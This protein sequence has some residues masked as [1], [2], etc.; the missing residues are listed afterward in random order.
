[1]GQSLK[2]ELEAAYAKCRGADFVRRQQGGAVR[3]NVKQAH[4]RGRFRN[5]GYFA[6]GSGNL[7]EYLSRGREFTK[8]E[9]RSISAY[10]PLWITVMGNWDIS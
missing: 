9:M 5:T 7:R 6:T 8:E 2:H 10:Q 1:M 4:G 3:R